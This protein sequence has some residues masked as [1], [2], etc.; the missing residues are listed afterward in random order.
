MLAQNTTNAD[1]L[2]VFGEIINLT[3]LS[4]SNLLDLLI[5]SCRRSISF[6]I[7]GKLFTLLIEFNDVVP[8]QPVA[9]HQRGI[10]Y[11]NGLLLARLVSF[12]QGLKKAKFLSEEE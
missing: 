7:L 5:D 3:D 4:E 10:D 8:K 12:G 11:L 6:A 1:D 9:Q 2:L